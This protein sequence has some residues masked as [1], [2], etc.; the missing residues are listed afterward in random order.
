MQRER[1][2]LEV[3]GGVEAEARWFEEWQ[4]FVIGTALHF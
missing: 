1:D 4:S 2:E 3:R